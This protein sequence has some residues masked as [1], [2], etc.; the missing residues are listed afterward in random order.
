[1]AS[2]IVFEGGYS[3][4]SGPNGW[5]AV[6]LDGVA[7]TVGIAPAGTP[8]NLGDQSAWTWCYWIRLDTQEDAV[9]FLSKDDG[10]HTGSDFAYIN[11][12]ATSG[13]SEWYSPAP[14]IADI[15]VIPDANWHFYLWTYNGSGVALYVDDSY[16]G[17]VATAT[18]GN[19]SGSLYVGGEN[20]SNVNSAITISQMRTYSTVLSAGDQTTL[21]GAGEVE[22]NQIGRWLFSE[23]SG[24]TVAQNAGAAPSA[25]NHAGQMIRRHRLARAG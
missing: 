1:M 25:N 22:T 8:I 20:V 18:I 16:I 11:G 10:A 15:Y 14:G 5:N 17:T 23:G 3:W 21:Y 7:G 6:Q 12:F 4:V 19:N 9:Y 2:D 13:S 24:T